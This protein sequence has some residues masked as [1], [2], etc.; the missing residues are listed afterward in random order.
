[1]SSISDD[2]IYLSGLVN[3]QTVSIMLDT[4]ATVSVLSDEM[5]RKCGRNSCL[6]PVTA[7]LTAA[8]SNE[9]EVQ[10]QA[11]IRLR[12]ADFDT[13]WTVIVARELSHDC[14]LGTDFFQEYKCKICYDTGTFMVG[15]TE[16]PIRYQKVKPV[17]CRVILQ[18]DTEIEPGTEQIV[19][20]R[21]E[22]GFERNSGS[23][24]IIEG[25][26]T[27]R[28]NKEVCVGRSLVVPKNRDTPVRVANFTD[29]VI[30]LPTGHVIGFYHP[31]RPN[32][33][34]APFMRRT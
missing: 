26:K 22:I 18:S 32:P 33:N 16:V 2:G 30:K 8:N 27:V 1:M 20:G 31:L 23:P 25:M 11:A 9:I 17:A 7:T 6:K 10:G 15:A 34:A 4:G 28:K 3:H 24:G 5:W 14:L 13:S 29:R 12:I 19:G 21:L